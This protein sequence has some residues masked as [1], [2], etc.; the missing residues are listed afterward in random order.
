MFIVFQTFF[1]FGKHKFLKA[2]IITMPKATKKGMFSRYSFFSTKAFIVKTMIN[3]IK[4][5]IVA[6]LAPFAEF[7]L[8]ASQILMLLALDS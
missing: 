8:Q 5:P 6:I 7:S 2:I 4:V 3:V 1:N